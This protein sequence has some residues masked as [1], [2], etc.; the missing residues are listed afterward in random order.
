MTSRPSARP[1]HRDDDEVAAEFARILSDEGLALRPGAVPHEPPAPPP[2]SAA[3]AASPASPSPE[4]RER[5]RERA[6][7]AHPSARRPARGA[8]SQD[9][10][11]EDPLL[12][13]FVPPDPRVPAPSDGALWAWVGLIAGVV[14]LLLTATT[15]LL[16]AW[17]GPLGA[18]VAVA[19][20]VALLL[21]V[22]RGRDPFDDGAQV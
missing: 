4:E 22:P 13:D 12:G 18:V 3:S 9:E 7:A 2:S 11:D 15:Q 6:R 21:R 10:E 14:L 20:L 17:C 8:A 16:P 1:P 5:E 19:G